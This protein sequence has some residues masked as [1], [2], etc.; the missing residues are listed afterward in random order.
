MF[1]GL[2]EIQLFDQTLYADNLP[3]WTLPTLSLSS[4]R[5]IN[6]NAPFVKPCLAMCHRW[7]PYLSSQPGKV[8]GQDS[9]SYTKIS[10]HGGGSKTKARN[11]QFH[12]SRQEVVWEKQQMGCGPLSISEYS[13]LSGISEYDLFERK[14]FWM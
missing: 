1:G 9:I 6:F 8:K 14:S 7:A 13:C 3:P 5:H 11:Y 2:S 4:P 10:V 12:K